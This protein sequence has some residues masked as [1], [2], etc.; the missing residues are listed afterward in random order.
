[1]FAYVFLCMLC[2]SGA[3]AEHHDHL[4][5]FFCQIRFMMAVTRRLVIFLSPVWAA[6]HVPVELGAGWDLWSTD[7]DKCNVCADVPISALKKSAS[8]HHIGCVNDQTYH[9]VPDCDVD[10]DFEAQAGGH[11]GDF[12]IVSGGHVAKKF[13]TSTTN[14]CETGS[15][16]QCR[17]YKSGIIEH[18]AYMQFWCL[19]RF[20][21]A[22]SGAAKSTSRGREIANTA[23]SL[24]PF[25][26]GSDAWAPKFYGVCKRTNHNETALYLVMENLFA[27][28]TKVSQLDLKVGNSYE[29]KAISTDGSAK[30]HVQAKIIDKFTPTSLFK[31]RVAG[32]KVWK[33]DEGKYRKMSKKSTSP[34]MNL[35]KVFNRLIVVPGR[36]DDI[37][38]MSKMADKTMDMAVWWLTTGV[39][40]VRSI[41]ASILFIFEGDPDA[42]QKST[43]KFIDYAHFYSRQEKP[44]WPDDGVANGLFSATNYIDRLREAALRRK[45]VSGLVIGS[46]VCGRQRTCFQKCNHS[47]SVAPVLE[48]RC[49]DL[50]KRLNSQYASWYSK[51]RF[52]VCRVCKRL[53]DGVSIGWKVRKIGE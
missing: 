35:H 10:S 43:V 45:K 7:P 27:G 11:I 26:V 49:A 13:T 16:E 31:A 39:D 9:S 33:P 37:E 34:M 50:G 53:Q 38:L 46:E 25:V 52:P 28:Y 2:S 40:T 21:D 19:S 1:M 12:F 18:A 4:C 15:P 42:P 51:P 29:P 23:H 5:R 41:S 36:E 14:P 24:D 48:E 44:H 17:R 8:S 20:R 47:I 32:Y 22:S 6:R 30:G 3:L